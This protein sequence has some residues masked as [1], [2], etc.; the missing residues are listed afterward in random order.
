MVCYLMGQSLLRRL[1]VSDRMLFTTFIMS[2]FD[3][4]KVESEVKYL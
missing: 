2:H 1:V 3:W 4:K